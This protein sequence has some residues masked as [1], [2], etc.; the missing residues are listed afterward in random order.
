MK[1]IRKYAAVMPA[2]VILTIT[3]LPG[4]GAAQSDTGGYYV[5][6]KHVISSKILN[7][8][9]PVY[10]NLPKAYD[11]LDD[12]Y[13]VCYLLDAEIHYEYAAGMISYLG[14]MGRIPEMI[15]VGIPSLHRARDMTP[16]AIVDDTSGYYTA[17]GGGDNFL[18][19]ITDELDPY[20]T[21]AYR[22]APFR[23]VFGHCLAGMFAV[24]ATLNQP[25]WFNA[26]IAISPALWYADDYVISLLD[27]TLTDYDPSKLLYVTMGTGEDSLT[28]AAYG[29]LQTVLDSRTPAGLHY[30]FNELAGESHMSLTV[31]SLIN[32]LDWLY[33]S[34]NF[35][36]DTGE[37]TTEMVTD[38]CKNL[39]EYYGYRIVPPEKVV[40]RL[41][42]H[43]YNQ[44]DYD[45]ARSLF[46]LNQKHHPN[47]LNTHDS[48]GEVCEILGDY[49][50][51]LTH[52]RRALQ[53]SDDSGNGYHDFFERKIQRV[54]EKMNE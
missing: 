10:I 27:S 5:G 15:V 31:Q 40:N 43:Y 29:R 24:H 26:C 41:G 13:P 53:L 50:I 28:L 52:Y 17:A 18:K 3:L 9:R 45:R 49:E 22:T 30:R 16:V 11:L 54:R 20:I 39:S 38:K 32:G 36:P 7:E 21:S 47:S 33:A 42:Y 51:A 35:I 4:P 19:F 6:T 48:M 23:I 1:E 25:D 8:D 46:T 37:V 2:L 14:G 34:W 12:S 44:K